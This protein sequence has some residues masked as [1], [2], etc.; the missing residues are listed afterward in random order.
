[1]NEAFKSKWL[2]RFAKEDD[3]MWKNVIKA[4]YGIYELGGWSKKSLVNQLIASEVH[5]TAN[6]GMMIRPVHY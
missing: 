6:P 1:M 2:W 4:K 5:R 3:A